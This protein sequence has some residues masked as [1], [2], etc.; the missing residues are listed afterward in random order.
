MRFW[1]VS[2]SLAIALMFLLSTFGMVVPAAATTTTAEYI[3]VDGILS[4]DWYTLSGDKIYVYNLYP[5]EK[6][7]TSIG[8]NKY[9]E[10]IYV[11]PSYVDAEGYVSN[12]AIGVGL[13]YAGYEDVGTYD[14]RVGDVSGVP[15]RDPFANEN[16]RDKFDWLNGWLIDIRYTYVGGIDRHVWAFALFGDKHKAGGP[17]LNLQTGVSTPNQGGRQCNKYAESEP[18]NIL[19]HGPRRWVAQAVTHIFDGDDTNGNG[20]LEQDERWPLVDVV[21]TQV[22]DKVKKQFIL[23]KDIKLTIDSK[24][25]SGSVDIAFSNRG[26]WDLG[27][28]PELDSYSHFWHQVYT[29]CFGSDWHLTKYPLR[30]YKFETTGTFGAY[31]SETVT[32]PEDKTEDPKWCYPVEEDSE[33]VYITDAS[34]TTTFLQR[35]I[36]YTIDYDTGVITFLKVYSGK[37]TVYYKLHKCADSGYMTEIPSKYD[38]AQVIA[39][40][41]KVVGYAA[42]WPILSDYTVDGW[43]YWNQPLFNVDDEDMVTVSEPE[44]PFIIGEWDFM[45]GGDWPHQFRGVTVYGVVDYHDAQD[46]DA[47][48]ETDALDSEVKYLLNQVFNPWDLRKALHMPAGRYVEY[49]T[50]TTG[51]I[52]TSTDNVPVIVVDDED[53][54]SYCSFSERVLKDTDGDGVYET[55]IPRVSWANGTL[56]TN[57]TVTQNS[58]GTMTITGLSPGDYKVLYST[59]GLYWTTEDNENNDLTGTAD[60]DMDTE[61]CLFATDSK[62][63]IEFNIFTPAFKTAQSGYIAATLKIRALDVNK[64]SGEIDAVYVNGHYCGILTGHSEEWSVSEFRIPAEFL[65]TSGKQLVQI[66]ISCDSTKPIP[67]EITP[68]DPTTWPETTD[69]WCAIVDWGKLVFKPSYE[70]IVVGR[71]SAA[72]DSAGAAM[73]SEFF[74]SKKQTE[75]RMSGLD[76][77]DTVW[78]D[79]TPWVMQWM[80]DT[81]DPDQVE[82][83]PGG[84]YQKHRVHY[85]LD[86]NADSW[87]WI[88]ENVGRSGLRDAW[89]KTVPV[90]SASLI[91]IGSNWANLLSEYANEFTDAYLDMGIASGT[92]ADGKEGLT[93]IPLSCWSIWNVD[94]TGPAGWENASPWKDSSLNKYTDS[95]YAVISTFK[96]LDGTVILSIWGITGQDTYYACKFFWDELGEHLQSKPNCATTVIIKIDYTSCPYSYSVVETLGPISEYKHEGGIHDP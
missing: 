77:Q 46:K 16:V 20:V 61:E 92:L 25:L 27:P 60:N 64:Q 23:F 73:V 88:G 67:N 65:D 14:Q 47:G 17:W 43:A 96:D 41:E 89:C 30:E 7:S 74:D 79:K 33:R 28:P 93:I 37:L 5:F 54:A 45:L 78:G 44:I 76:M 13:Q 87:P 71:D 83:R 81:T 48:D 84:T 18:L 69:E 34:G 57:Y 32:L 52:T 26:Q 36:D 12:D 94:G 70:W 31:G 40:D 50:T 82:V 68:N 19:Y 59:Y 55:F 22:Y 49:H 11:D 21:I 9:G 8:F 72:V 62:H 3:K 66:F 53:W 24:K 1:K 10:C 90:E 35:G 39:S 42:Y 2:I 63:P 58:D 86:G 56:T 4:S 75:V 15:N 29:T 91:T 38:V 95:G 51:T 85:Y 6:R 80:R